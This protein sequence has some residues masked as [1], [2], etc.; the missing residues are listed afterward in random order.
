MGFAT[1]PFRPF[2]RLFKSGLRGSEGT[3]F[4]GVVRGMHDE[5]HGRTVGCMTVSNCHRSSV[6]ER[7]LGKDEVTGSNPVGGFSNDALL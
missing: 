1:L 7:I 4:L 5:R 6:V 3:G 2:G